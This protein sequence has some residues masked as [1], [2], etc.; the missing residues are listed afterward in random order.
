[1]TTAAPPKVSEVL[2]R[3]L[4]EDLQKMAGQYEGNQSNADDDKWNIARRVNEDWSEHKG[5]FDTRLE[6]FAECSR[7]MNLGR[8]KKYFSDSGETLRKWCEVQASYQR[9]ESEVNDGDKFLDLLSFDHLLKA[10]TLYNNA[11]VKSPLDALNAALENGWT[12]DEMAYHYDPPQAPD[13]WDV[14]QGHIQMMKSKDFWKLKDPKR[15]Q[16][17][18]HH[19]SQIEMIVEEEFPTWQK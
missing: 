15:V 8:K 5:Y 11:K 10:R 18:L 3:Y 4:C 17:V 2:D 1:M 6:Y 14:M 7:V 13:E 12:A 19:V 16:Q 9:F